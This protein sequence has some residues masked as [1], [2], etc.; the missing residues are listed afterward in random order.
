MV[1]DLT[2][3]FYHHSFFCSV[4][5]DDKRNC[6]TGFITVPA[7][8]YLFGID[9][10]VVNHHHAPS[11]KKALSR[12]F[13]EDDIQWTFAIRPHMFYLSA[14]QEVQVDH[15]VEVLK[16]TADSFY[17]G[18][19]LE[20]T[21]RLCKRDLS[22]YDPYYATRHGIPPDDYS[23][24]PF[25][26]PQSFA[27]GVLVALVCVLVV[28]GAGTAKVKAQSVV[29]TNSTQAICNTVSSAFYIQFT[30]SNYQNQLFQ[31]CFDCICS[32]ATAADTGGSNLEN[33]RVRLVAGNNDYADLDASKNIGCTLVDSV[34]Q[35]S[36][37]LTVT[38]IHGGSSCGL[39]ASA[40]ACGQSPSD[41]SN[42]FE[43]N[44]NILIIVGCV[45]G[46]IVVLAVLVG[47]IRSCCCPNK[48]SPR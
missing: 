27:A 29:P 44:K 15:L 39:I 24:P 20:P 18:E 34:A 13:R 6:H 21:E 22:A 12:S 35:S 4:D 41:S 30:L 19:L 28:F 25:T 45:V 37:T 33:S 47:I 1:S 23:P 40:E 7:S 14:A 46:G 26:R 48:V 31:S 2:P 38:Y 43:T 8:H 16:N 3:A 42:W 36:T 9:Y 10:E 17:R 11:V 32:N 5:F